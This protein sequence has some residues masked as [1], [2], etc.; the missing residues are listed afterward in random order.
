MVPEVCI[1]FSGRLL[2]GNRSTKRN[3]D[4]F[5]A[6]DSFNYPHLCEAGVTFNFNTHNILQPDYSRPV[7]PHLLLNPNVVVLSLFP[8]LQPQLIRHVLDTP[9]LRSIVMRTFGSGNA[10][11][12]PWLLELLGEACRRGVVVVNISQCAKGRVEMSRYDAGLRLSEAGVV[13]GYDSTVEAAVTKLM[14]LH[15][16]CADADEVRRL[17]NQ[18]LAGEIT[19]EAVGGA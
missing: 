15:A 5:N 14:H 6:F 10:P 7:V 1:Y 17:M 13:S 9:A 4:G 2:R 18:S 8:G 3:A 11:H 19:P 16:R 12:A